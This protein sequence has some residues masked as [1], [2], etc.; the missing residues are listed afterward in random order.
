M[1][2]S[3][4]SGSGSGYIHNEGW[5]K[6]ELVEKHVHFLRDLLRLWSHF[7]SDERET[8]E[9]AVNRL[10]SSIYRNRGRFRSQDRI[11]DAAICLE[12]MY[13][14]RP[15]ELT[16]KLAIRAAYLLAKETDKRIE[17]FH[18]VYAFYDARSNIAHG[19]KGKR[20]RTGEKKTTDLEEAADL[21]FVLAS[22]SLR[23]LLE[24]GEFP[25]WKELIMSP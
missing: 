12:I 25:K 16:N 6:K 8:L 20:Q 14:L 24:Y 18:Q 17:I 21:G 2:P 19:S 23:A 7:K 15:P 4:V 11:L 9:M 22:K 10:S 1:S 3:F 13:Q 5:S